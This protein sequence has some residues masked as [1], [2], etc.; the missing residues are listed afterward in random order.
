MNKERFFK[1]ISEYRSAIM[2][3]AI[4]AII[5][6]HQK[7]VT[8]F[9]LSIFQYYGYWGVDMFLLLSGMGLVNSLHKNPIRQYYQRRIIRLAP[10]CVLCGVLKCII[11]LLLGV[12]ITGTDKLHLNWLSPLG[13]DLWYI[14]AILVYYL[15][16]PLLYKYLEKSPWLTMAA[17][18]LFFTVNELFFRIHDSNSPTWIPERLPIFT[19]GML[20]V[21]RK[22][23]LSAKTMA[24]SIGFLMLAIGIVAIYKENIYSTLPWAA[25][26]F[27]LAFGTTGIIR[28]LT[29][30]FKYIPLSL[31][32]P[33]QWIGT[34]SL[35]IYVIHEFI[36]GVIRISLG[37]QYNPLFLLLL[38][39]T[40]SILIAYLCKWATDIIKR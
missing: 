28:I 2:G 31:L 33:I 37:S 36:F 12:F 8:A 3:L 35:E 38:G 9:P 6:F 39:I 32:S 21:I 20:L 13:L 7:F 25:H 29:F 19:I 30:L 17:I 27:A 22:G 4:I 5:L 1:D 10:S 24:L 34:I 40:L 18:L 14:R 16:S 23:I 11:F 15:I 26:M